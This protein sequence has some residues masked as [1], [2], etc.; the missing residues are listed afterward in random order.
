MS[1][2]TYQRNH[3]SLAQRWQAETRKIGWVEAVAVPAARAAV[4]KTQAALQLDE[5]HGQS[6]CLHFGTWR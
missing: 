5:P 1:P 6:G 4:A 2:S 3:L